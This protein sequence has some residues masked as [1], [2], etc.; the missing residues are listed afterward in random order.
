M[1]RPFSLACFKGCS[2][3]CVLSMSSSERLFTQLINI[4]VGSLPRSCVRVCW[5]EVIL[6]AGPSRNT[7][8]SL[9]PTFPFNIPCWTSIWLNGMVVK[10]VIFPLRASRDWSAMPDKGLLLV[11]RENLHEHMM[12]LKSRCLWG[13]WNSFCEWALVHGCFIWTRTWSTTT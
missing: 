7:H 6:T 4:W 10:R 5:C 3:D 9:K 8:V 13:T 12:D 11:S 1:H 2:M